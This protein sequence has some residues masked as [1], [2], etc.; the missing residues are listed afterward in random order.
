MLHHVHILGGISRNL[1]MP[2][3]VNI[4]LKSMLIYKRSLWWDV[5]RF[6]LTDV[7]KVR[8][9][10][11][12]LDVSLLLISATVYFWHMAW[13]RQRPACNEKQK[14]ITTMFRLNA[15]LNLGLIIP[16]K[17]PFILSCTCA[18]FVC[19]RRKISFVLNSKRDANGGNRFNH[20]WENVSSPVYIYI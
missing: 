7:S 10:K 18:L 4:P 14:G 13:R 16:Y 20:C 2:K 19:K 5:N 9:T 12:L 6:R 1:H 11:I 3:A 8:L 15:L 17:Y